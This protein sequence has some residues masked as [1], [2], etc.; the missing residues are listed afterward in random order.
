MKKFFLFLLFTILLPSLCFSYEET[1]LGPIFEYKKDE[2]SKVYAFRPL[3]YY[4]ANYEL[5][6]RSL[7]V[8]YPLIGYQ[9]DNQ[10]SQFQAFFSMIRYKNFNDY[11]NLQEKNLSIFPILDVS[12]SGKEDNNYFSLFPIYGNLKDKYTKDEIKYFLFPLYLKTIEKNSSNT[13]FLWPFIAKTEGKYTSGFKLWPLFGYSNKVDQ[14]RLEV[15]KESKFFLWPFY[16]YKKDLSKGLDLEEKV[17]FPIYLTSSST[18]HQSK[19]FLWPFF[20]VYTDKVR[21]QTTYN[22]PWP[23]VQYKKGVNIKSKRFFPFYSYVKSKNVEKGFFLWPVYKYKNEILSTDYFK[24]KSFLL[25]IYKQDTYYDLRDNTISREFS[26]LWPIYS[27][28]TFEGGYEFHIFSPLESFF[29]K[30]EKLRKFWSPMWSIF[31]IRNDE[32]SSET[33]ILFNLIRFERDKVNNRK[34]FSINF[35]LPIVSSEVHNKERKFNILGGLLGLETG[36]KSKIRILYIP[37]NI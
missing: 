9:E 10:Q 36:E 31:R 30:N 29:S 28:D 12:W 14:Q 24:T 1:F 32:N 2:N 22:M 26:S 16:S 33:S 18:V 34:E 35:I 4:E 17:Y 21:N 6:Y 23:L 13:H 7:D 11:D 27:K 15:I 25:F 19:T 8:I 3:F 37:I 20:N 5:K